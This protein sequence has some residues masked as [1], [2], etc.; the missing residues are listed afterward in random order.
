MADGISQ[1]VSAALKDAY[2]GFYLALRVRQ[3]KVCFSLA[4]ILVPACIGLDYFVYP[5]LAWP[6][7]KARLW[8]DFAM[9]PA[10]AALF[11]ERGQKRVRWLDSAPL[12]LAALA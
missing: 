12:L 6:M 2:S 5:H 8:C 4:M 1:P 7:F 9:A 11:T 3:A 10:F